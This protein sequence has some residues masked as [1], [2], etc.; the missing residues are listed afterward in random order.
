[1]KKTNNE[2]NVTTRLQSNKTDQ[3]ISQSQFS[4]ADHRKS[5][6]KKKPANTN[7]A[8]TTKNSSTNSNTLK[9]NRIPE[10]KKIERIHYQA[11]HPNS[12]RLLNVFKD[13][14]FTGKEI[15]LKI[16]KVVNECPVCNAT[17]NKAKPRKQAVGITK[18]SK[19]STETIF[20]DHKQVGSK[21]RKEQA[22]RIDSLG[23]AADDANFEKPIILTIYEPLSGAV[24]AIPVTDY[25]QEEVRD[26]LRVY[27]QIHG[28]VE[29]VISDNHKAFEN[30]DSW[31]LDKFGCRHHYVSNYHPNSNL[32]E[33]IHR[34][35]NSNL[36]KYNPKTK[37]YN[38][39]NWK[40]SITQ[41]VIQHNSIKKNLYAP[42]EITKN[43]KIMNLDP[44]RFKQTKSEKANHENQFKQK[45][46]KVLNSKLK[47]KNRIFTPDENV[48]VIFPGQKARLAIVQS[49]CDSLYKT[50]I[51]VKFRDKS[52]SRT[53]NKDYI[54]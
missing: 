33:R 34:Y 26:A 13:L 4:A 40:D 49:K 44:T 29:N 42:F 1:M 15:E 14:G 6:K 39:S 51:K 3:N 41:Y 50:A 20:I 45:V 9:F 38:F 5:E 16:E 54:C 22:M 43:R 35:F 12:R 7:K 25:S 24:T 27:F 46:G 11:N 23:N 28:P 37:E 36:D 19:T 52:D 2:I 8:I 53:V 32:S 21:W 48:K 30:L 18:T 10:I 47:I 17:I 31:L